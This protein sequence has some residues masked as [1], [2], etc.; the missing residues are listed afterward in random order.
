MLRKNFIGRYL[1]GYHGC[2]RS[3]GEDVLSGRISHLKESSNPWDWLGPGV[4]FWIDNPQRAIAWASERARIPGHRIKQP[5]AVG[6]Y[7]QLGRCLN[8]TDYGTNEEMRFA[9]RS[10]CDIVSA[11]GS[12]LPKNDRVDSSGVSVRRALDCA[13]FQ[14][15]HRLRKQDSQPP[16]DAVI[17]VFE[18]GG[19]LFEGSAIKEKSHIQVAVLNPSDSIVGYFRVPGL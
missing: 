2:D 15:V 16:Y 6:A 10:L 12:E 8:L 3:T 7:L 14:T 5:Y 1:V 17:G 4:Y 13:V 18:E 19:P 11:S 9:H